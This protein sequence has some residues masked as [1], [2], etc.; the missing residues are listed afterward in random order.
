MTTILTPAAALQHRPQPGRWLA[1]R[2]PD[3]GH[4]RERLWLLE[5]L[6]AL[7]LLLV[8]FA[9]PALARL[10]SV[11]AL[12]SPDALA[13][14]SWSADPLRWISAGAALALLAG[15]APAG[16]VL[17]FGVL[18]LSALSSR[19]GGAVWNYNLHL[20]WFLLMCRQ[21]GSAPRAALA[22]VQVS[23]ALFYLQAGL[24]KLLASGPHWFLSGDTLR[25]YAPY[26]GTGLGRSLAAH[27]AW[28]AA[29][30]QATGVVEFALPVLLLL[31]RTQALSVPV[32]WAFHLGVAAT[33]GIGFWQLTLLYPAVFYQAPVRRLGRFLR[34]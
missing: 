34:I 17:A 14:W 29:I 28:C 5:R 30:T 6:I 3:L 21:A 15:V 1:E 7:W 11:M 22:C 27:P 9:D 12:S 2:G 31:R 8:L 10:G 20:F 23:V 13:A 32:A 24:T 4:A 33:F 19:V 26:L 16:W 25:H 18:G